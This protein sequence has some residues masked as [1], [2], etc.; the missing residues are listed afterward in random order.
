MCRS[1]Q[2]ERGVHVINQLINQFKEILDNVWEWFLIVWAGTY[3][4]FRYLFQP[5]SAWN[6]VWLMFLLSFVTKLIQMSFEEKSFRKMLRKRFSSKIAI[7]KAVPKIFL[8]LTLM[9]ATARANDVFPEVVSINLHFVFT[10]FVFAMELINSLQHLNQV[11]G[12]DASGLIGWVKKTIMPK[13]VGNDE[14]LR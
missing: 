1:N 13:G 8:Y 9:F 11:E 10:A 2:S 4:I 12:V 14:D 6:A 3:A 7:Q 5:T